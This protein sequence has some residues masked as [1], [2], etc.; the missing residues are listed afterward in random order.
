MSRIDEILQE[1]PPKEASMVYTDRAKALETD[2]AQEQIITMVRSGFP[3]GTM[4]VTDRR[5]I[6]LLQDG[7]GVQVI[8][9]ADISSLDMLDGGKGMMGFGAPKPPTVVVRY[10]S[11][12][13]S[14]AIAIGRDGAW[15]QRAANVIIQQHQRFTIS[16]I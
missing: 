15:G 16:G 13:G 2:L 6:V 12:K 7:G 4:V 3:F 14:D 10:H 9:F 5:L 1:M 11:G 8:P